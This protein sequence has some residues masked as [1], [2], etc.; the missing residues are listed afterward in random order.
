MPQKI[1]K[2]RCDHL[3]SFPPIPLSTFL[4]IRINP[5]LSPFPLGRSRHEHQNFTVS[6][7]SPAR[8]S[9]STGALQLC[10]YLYG[11]SPF[12]GDIL[13]GHTGTTAA[14]L[15]YTQTVSLPVCEK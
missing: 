4:P 8:L 1:N 11:N 3:S 10:V 12:S 14:E 2:D 13:G 7:I 6:N 9:R 5:N 15:E